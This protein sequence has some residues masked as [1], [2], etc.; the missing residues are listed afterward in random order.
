LRD[1]AGLSPDFAD[2]LPPQAV[3]GSRVTYKTCRNI[4]KATVEATARRTGEHWAD[5]ID[6]LEHTKSL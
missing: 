5:P 6:G 2:W 4:V 1:S 3:L